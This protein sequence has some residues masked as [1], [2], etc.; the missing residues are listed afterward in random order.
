MLS[1]HT[2][3]ANLGRMTAATI[4][5]LAGGQACGL[6]DDGACPA[7]N[8]EGIRVDVVDAGLER[9]IPHSAN[10]MGVVIHEGVREPMFLQP[11]F[12]DAPTQLSGGDPPPGVRSAVLVYDVEIT[13]DG[14][15][16]WHANGIR[17]EVDN[18]G[19]ARTVEM[20]ARL[21]PLAPT[22]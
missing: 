21:T 6:F 7:W 18:C 8:P 19:H 17:V 13:A 2:G 20:T 11:A 10:P 3:P 1:R 12:P 9:P 22:G 4:L 5:V 16:A 15:A 14:Y